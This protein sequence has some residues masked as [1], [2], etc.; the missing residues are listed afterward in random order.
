VKRLSDM[1][2]ILESIQNKV[3][4]RTKTSLNFTIPALGSAQRI[5]ESLAI[6]DQG[7]DFTAILDELD[8]LEN[9]V[10]VLKVKVA[11]QDII[12]T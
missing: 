3:F 10:D 5:K 4:F 7:G 2:N 11:S 6:M 8:S 12:I 9:Q 1:V